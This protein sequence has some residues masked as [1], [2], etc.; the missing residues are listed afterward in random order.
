MALPATFNKLY[1]GYLLFN[2]FRNLGEHWL[3]KDLCSQ[4]K[5]WSKLQVS[6][7]FFLVHSTHAET[8]IPE[9]IEKFG[10]CL[11]HALQ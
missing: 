9:L 2:P 3:S 8:N 1:R 5:S 6:F 7:S 10:F 11:A 4:E